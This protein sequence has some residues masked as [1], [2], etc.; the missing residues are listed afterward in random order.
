[1]YI[2]SFASRVIL[3]NYTYKGNNLTQKES[4]TNGISNQSQA[5]ETDI[6]E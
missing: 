4:H 5:I 6:L 1:M 2:R 3:K